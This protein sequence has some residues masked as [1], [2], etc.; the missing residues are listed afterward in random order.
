M[1]SPHDTI[2]SQLRGFHPGDGYSL[3]QPSPSRDSPKSIQLAF[4]VQPSGIDIPKKTH[5]T[6]PHARHPKATRQL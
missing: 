1:T 3:A 2:S 6:L 5:R 4:P